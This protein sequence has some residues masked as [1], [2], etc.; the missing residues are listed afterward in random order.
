M[1]MGSA[2]AAK[3]CNIVGTFTDTLGSM[4]QFTSEKA[5]TATNAVACSTTYKL[6]VTKLS[7]TVLDIKG[8]AKKC[9]ALTGDF[10]FDAGSCTTASGSLIVK[11]LGTFNDTITIMNTAVKSKPVD[12]SA[13]INGLK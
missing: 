4:G 10:T 12:N 7:N 8:K 3:K 11:G 9:G 13:L 6:T 1:N 2:S 5:G